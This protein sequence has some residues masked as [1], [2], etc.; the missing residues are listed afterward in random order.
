M[1]GL[2]SNAHL[3]LDGLWGALAV[4]DYCRCSRQEKNHYRVVV[5]ECAALP[6]GEGSAGMRSE[7]SRS[8]SRSRN[9][10]RPR[11]FGGDGSA[12]GRQG[13]RTGRRAGQ[14][15]PGRREGILGKGINSPFGFTVT[16][17]PASI[18]CGCRCLP[19]KVCSPGLEVC[20]SSQALARSAGGWNETLT[21]KLD[22]RKKLFTMRVG[23]NWNSL[24][25]KLWTPHPWECSKPA[26][27][28]P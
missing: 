23:R 8:S 13:A 20:A 24:P 12:G 14:G 3:W 18:L 21:D 28:R 27:M 26:W 2:A 7:S 1:Q 10:R 6:A 9:R 15:G 4:S 5:A 16:A 22:V 11:R 25:E 19:G 17:H